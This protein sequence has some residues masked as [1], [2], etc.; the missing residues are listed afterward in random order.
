MTL[1]FL[2][3]ASWWANVSVVSLTGLLAI[4]GLVAWYFSNAVGAKKD[5][6]H[7]RLVLELERVKA[8]RTIKEEH[9]EA[10]IRALSAFKG[11]MVLIG[12]IPKTHETTTFGVELV[13]LLKAAGLDA[14]VN[15]AYV[16]YR[17][18]ITRGVAIRYRA[19]NDK[20]KRLADALSKALTESA[21]TAFS[22]G[23]LEEEVVNR[24]EREKGMPRDHMNWESIAVAVGDKP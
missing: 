20:G 5:E 18:G 9:R 4:A 13:H 11:Q 21:I 6:E 22:A 23:G 8:P 17:I 7:A 16:G 19:G 2:E 12:A 1:E 24:M 15:D 10:F 3:K 14:V